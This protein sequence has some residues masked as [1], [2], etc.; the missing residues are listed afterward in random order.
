MPPSSACSRPALYD[1]VWTS[2]IRSHA[3]FAL[4]LAAFGLL[5]YGR[6]SPL[7]VVVLVTLAALVAPHSDHGRGTHKETARTSRAEGTLNGG[8]REVPRR[9][10]F[11]E[12][13]GIACG[14]V[15]TGRPRESSV[16]Q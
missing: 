14:P 15:E 10:P 3:D 6:Q 1:P 4:A 8:I 11:R 12:T 16:A 5:V 13:T 2:A 7:R 9:Q